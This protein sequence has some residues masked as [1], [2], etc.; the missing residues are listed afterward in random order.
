M[1]MSFARTLPRGG[2]TGVLI[3]MATGFGL[4]AAGSGIRTNVLVGRPITTD[5]GSGSRVKAGAGYRATNGRRLGFL[6]V[7][8][9][10]MS[11][12]RRY[13]RMPG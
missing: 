6:G 1:G 12:G 7:R 5:A 9:T 3:A 11:A 8:A 4:I 10:T 13:R 2:D